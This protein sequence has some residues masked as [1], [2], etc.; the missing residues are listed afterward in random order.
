MMDS[1]VF[2]KPNARHCLSVISSSEGK[3]SGG[4][5]HPGLEVPFFCGNPP[6]AN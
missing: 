6:A 4:E 5:R 3:D 1:K 2:W